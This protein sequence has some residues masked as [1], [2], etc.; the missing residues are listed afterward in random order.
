MDGSLKRRCLIPCASQFDFPSPEN[1][2]RILILVEPL[3]YPPSAEALGFRCYPVWPQGDGSIGEPKTEMPELWRSL[4]WIWISNFHLPGGPEKLLPLLCWCRFI[5]PGGVA[6]GPV[7][8]A[9]GPSCRR[10]VWPIT[11]SAWIWWR[12]ADFQLHAA[13]NMN[14][15]IVSC[16]VS[17]VLINSGSLMRLVHVGTLKCDTSQIWPIRRSDCDMAFKAAPVTQLNLKPMQLGH[18]PICLVS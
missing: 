15:H 7:L 4:P 3:N 6:P 8:D 9:G 18:R 5:G 13:P 10:P 16:H 17:P 14:S 2:L 11:V 1:H 12:S